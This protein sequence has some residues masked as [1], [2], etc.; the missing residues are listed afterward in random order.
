VSIT[1]AA[2]ENMSGL[3]SHTFSAMKMNERNETMSEL[4]TNVDSLLSLV[5]IQ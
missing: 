4:W 2:N 1:L 3:V 5:I